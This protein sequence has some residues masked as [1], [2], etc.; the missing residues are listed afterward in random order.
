[1]VHTAPRKLVPRELPLPAVDAD[2][3]AVQVSISDLS[4]LL[5]GI[6]PASVRRQK[7]FSLQ[8]HRLGDQELQ[9]QPIHLP[10]NKHL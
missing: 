5:W 7:R 2:T 3:R 1:M 6:E 8:A 10:S 4:L 9:A